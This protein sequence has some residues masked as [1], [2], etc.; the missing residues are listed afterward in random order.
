MLEMIMAECSL[1][2]THQPS[3]Q[4]SGYSVAARQKILSDI[5]LIPHHFMSIAKGFQ[6]IAS[7][8]SIS[9]HNTARYHCL[10]NDWLQ[11]AARSIR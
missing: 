9:A 1:M 11:P 5:R 2:S 10:L 6:S 8:S 3:L 4:Q 7:V